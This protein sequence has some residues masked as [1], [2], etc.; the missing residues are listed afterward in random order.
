VTVIRYT[1]AYIREVIFVSKLAQL[2]VSA[3][4]RGGESGGGISYLWS[5]SYIE[6]F[7]HA[8]TRLRATERVELSRDEPKRAGVTFEL[9]F[10]IILERLRGVPGHST[11]RGC[12][13]S[14]DHDD[15]QE[16]FVRP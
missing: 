2:D 4:V 9:P 12:R 11:S 7:H 8:A 16:V 3:P 5:S 14:I 10:S 15:E 6:L 1:N 13:S